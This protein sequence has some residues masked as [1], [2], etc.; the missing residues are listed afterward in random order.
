M[1]PS[2]S[3]IFFA[4][5]WEAGVTILRNAI[6]SF[7][8]VSQLTT[9][10]RWCFVGRIDSF[11]SKSS[12]R[13]TITQGGHA[14]KYNYGGKSESRTLFSAY[15]WIVFLTIFPLTRS[16]RG[17][18]ILEQWRTTARVKEDVEL[19]RS[20]VNIYSA[21]PFGPLGHSF[22]FVRKRGCEEWRDLF[23]GGDF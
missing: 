14:N 3:T 10:K 12:V 11:D 5:W 18:Q 1:A 20:Y 8:N 21:V 2:L 13:V 4:G 19:A 7:E 17:A 15:T 22:Y 23:L 6:P 9:S 16:P